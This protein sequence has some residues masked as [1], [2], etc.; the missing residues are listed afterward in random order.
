MTGT[1]HVFDTD[2]QPMTDYSVRFDDGYHRVTCSPRKLYP[3]HSCRKRRWASRL[4]IKVFYDMSIVD[5]VD[6]ARCEREKPRRK[7]RALV[8]R[9]QEGLIRGA[10][11][12]E[13]MLVVVP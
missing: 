1:V 12:I 11:V 4:R 9:A 2:W 3:C 6:Q 8:W 13:S 5:C 10:P 7:R